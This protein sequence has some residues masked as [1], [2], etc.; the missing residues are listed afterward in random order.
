MRR[1][2][3]RVAECA[4]NQAFESEEVGN[5]IISALE[6]D[7]RGEMSPEFI[8]NLHTACRGQ[9]GFLFKKDL[10][11]QL[12]ALRG[13]AG[14]GIERVVLDLAVEISASGTAGSDVP[15]KA[16]TDALTDHMARCA[17]QVE[18]HYCRKSIEPRANRVRA[19]IEQAVD[20]AAIEGLARQIL[21]AES[22]RS[23]RPPL[24]REGLDD[25]VRL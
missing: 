14:P 24:K 15:L 12:E 25:G 6:Q 9:E 11:P 19:R 7:C 8:S 3:K 13:A 22:G 17:R 21:T 16:M 18:E 20:R 1:G 2:W 10:G 23:G 5:A 4:D